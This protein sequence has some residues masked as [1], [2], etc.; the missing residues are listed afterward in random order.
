MQDQRELYQMLV[1]SVSAGKNCVL[2][3][4]VAVKGS[5][6]SNVGDKAIVENDTLKGWI[7]GGC[8]QGIVLAQAGQLLASFNHQ[9]VGARLIRVCPRADFVAE[10]ECYESHCPSEGSV[11]ILLECVG[12]APKILLYGNTPIAEHIATNIQNLSYHLQWVR[13]MKE[14]QLEIGDQGS[15]QDTEV[16]V[17]I[18]TTQG[19]GDIVALQHAL[20]SKTVQI[21]LVCS[22]KK[23]AALLDQLKQQGTDQL[24]LDRIISHAGIEIGATNAAEIA[25]SLVAQT[26]SLIRTPQVVTSVEQ[27]SKSVVQECKSIEPKVAELADRALPS[28]APSSCCA[29]Q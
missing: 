29:S 4:V 3:T 22:L 1:N 18:V 6:A 19:N 27:V 12:Q 9:G 26:V 5:A 25:L 16:Q 17:A 13:D 2:A 21:L 8:C 14:L 28:K 24:A 20:Q 15:K 7:G 10:V 23:S 11:D